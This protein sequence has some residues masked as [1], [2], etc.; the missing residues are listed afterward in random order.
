MENTVAFVHKVSRSLL[1]RR[2]A[3]YFIFLIYTGCEH[4]QTHG[5]VV[6]LVRDQLTKR[7]HS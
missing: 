5:L 1:K 3:I 2:N 7:E 4:C 6:Q